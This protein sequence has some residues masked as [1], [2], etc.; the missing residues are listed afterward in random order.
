MPEPVAAER[1]RSRPPP[2]RERRAPAAQAAAPA[3]TPA[4]AEPP[5][6]R[7]TGGPAPK[8]GGVPPSV[9]EA[10]SSPG[11]PLPAEV[12]TPLA[13]SLG[14]D[15]ADVRVHRD[16]RA[17]KAASDLGVR[18]F[19]YGRGVY[20]ARGERPTDLPL[21]AHEVAHVVQQQAG[22]AVQLFTSAPAADPLE[23]EAQSAAG[24]TARGAPAVVAG[25]TP[26]RVQGQEQPS[27]WERFKAWAGEKA[28][29]AVEFAGGAIW[30]L[31]ERY[32][33]SIVPILRK[34]VFEWLKEK[35]SDALHSLFETLAAPVRAVGGFVDALI[36]KFRGLVAWIREAA[37]Q[38]AT[39]ACEAVA[40]AADKVDKVVNGILEAE[41][42]VLGRLKNFA[43]K[44]GGFLKDAWNTLGAPVVDFM[45]KAAGAV[46]D[47]IV[48]IGRAIWD[49]TEPIRKLAA[50]AWK[51]AK[52][53]IGIGDEPENQNGIIQWIQRK[54]GE[55]WDWVK[56]R[57]EPIKRPLL[58]VGGILL[59]LS[60]AGPFIAI[61]GA[62]A[63]IVMGARWLW[64]N[65]RA[66]D[67]F[68]RLRQTLVSSILPAIV[69]TVGRV[70][71]VVRSA[72]SWIGGKLSELV[73][74]VG[75]FVSV[76]AT[77]VLRFAAAIVSWIAEQVRRLAS[78]AGDHLAALAQWVGSGLNRLY[79]FVRPVLEV[80]K[81]VISIVANPMGVTGL[82][83]GIFWRI[84]P[85]CL[86]RPLLRFILAIISGLLRLIPM[87][88]I[89]AL[90]ALI[91]E[92]LVGFVDK[93]RS[94]EGIAEQEKI[95]DRFAQMATRGSWDFVV[96]YVIGLLKGLWSGISGPFV[97]LWDIA[98]LIGNVISWLWNLAKSTVT[99]GFRNVVAGVQSAW[100][101]VQT[102]IWPAIEGFFKGPSDPMKIINTIRSLI[103]QAL[104]MAKSAG[105][106]VFGFL[107]GFLKKPDRE[108]GESI[109]EIVGNILFEVILT[110]VTAGGYAA[111]GPIQK[112]AQWA[113]KLVGRIGE[114]AA[115]L[116]AQFPRI[117]RFIESVGEFAATNPA[118]KKIVGAVKAVLEK[119]LGFLKMSYGLGGAA[120]RGAAKGERALTEA[121][122][123]AA[124]TE[125]RVAGTE[126]E[127]AAGERKVAAAERDLAAGERTVGEAE[128]V[129]ARA[130]G[131]VAKETKVIDA[132]GET[133]SY[134]VLEDGRIIRCSEKC[135]LLL[136][137]TTGRAKDL[138]KGRSRSSAI[139]KE[140]AALEKR[141]TALEAESKRVATLGRGERGPAQEKLL[142]DLR[143]LERDITAVEAKTG[144]VRWVEESAEM[145]AEA[146]AYQAKARGARPGEAPEIRYVEDGR[147]KKCRFDG[148]T[149][150]TLIDRK[151]SVTTF[152]KSERQVQRQ[153]DA[154]R[155]NGLKGLWEVPT[156]AEAARARQLIKG[157]GADDVLKVR[158]VAL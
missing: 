81:Q 76:V 133:H 113:T 7:L 26:P 50:A 54:A 22:P 115:E 140:A 63:G 128:R 3:R 82:L 61:G 55:A 74:A 78:W 12:R 37:G 92:A 152:P 103:D 16:E 15:V 120:E 24:A 143:E 150:D 88:A 77:P 53:I 98:K 66:P 95:A 112:L 48:S 100:A 39:K 25:R 89:G 69:N 131:G 10:L 70:V 67:A 1:E 9:S 118:M 141:A 59:M 11:E 71:G 117:M 137:S 62:V 146:E 19:A 144:K 139:G 14:V 34:G 73:G 60:P 99:S 79:E 45:K 87:P 27:R 94:A 20:L 4:P 121:E 46:W 105:E 17:N 119:I 123:A 58:V 127:I 122:R 36:G 96:G 91:R 23:R 38:L 84:I 42:T 106:K 155:A 44:V 129:G 138:L 40:Q 29:A 130:E 149:G 134:R 64:Q 148:K 75:S 32:A 102:Q 151:L 104:G 31:L 110:V 52:R 80:L 158:V 97:L 65:L 56:A 109:G 157:V 8:P 142:R 156:E 126:R 21:I 154:L 72:A 114:F 57:I 18:A 111:K 41:D 68:V 135:E 108:L 6:L 101:T 90:G 30:S 136:E 147:V 132:A 28:E 124:A 85:T 51:A 47:T 49:L 5:T 145:S 43:K 13:R 116:G 83:F 86:K 107:V 33:P 93:A 2:D 125:R 153:A 35:V